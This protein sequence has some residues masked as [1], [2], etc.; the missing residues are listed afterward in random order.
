LR[1]VPNPVYKVFM[2][3]FLDTSIIHVVWKYGEYIFD[4]GDLPET[5]KISTLRDGLK[6]LNSLAD[7]FV[8]DQRASSFPWII[9][10]ASIEEVAADGDIHYLD[11]A[12][13]YLNC[14]QQ[15]LEEPK[16][17]WINRAHWVGT[18]R[19]NYLGEGDRILLRDALW[20][21][22]DVF[23]TMERRL[24]KCADHIQ[25]HLKIR[26][27]RPPEFHKIVFKYDAC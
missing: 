8:L 23:L 13:E 26:I 5:G 15:F 11:Y 27:L 12:I 18:R 24:A 20:Q 10:R 16:P 4:G 21:G 2:R 9:S 7:L 14:S 6:D 17:G 19:F 3:V 22:C 25:K 1:H